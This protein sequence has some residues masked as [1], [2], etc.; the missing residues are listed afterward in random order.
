MIDKEN[1]IVVLGDGDV[2]IAYCETG[3][4]FGDSSV[5]DELAEQLEKSYMFGIQLNA[6]DIVMLDSLLDKVAAGD[7]DEFTYLDT[8]IKFKDSDDADRV[9]SVLAAWCELIFAKMKELE[10]YYN[11]ILKGKV[12][13]YGRY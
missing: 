13:N 10:L 7:I 3:I 12:K 9:R 6:A 8:T 4:M 2:K 1:R 11:S 5:P